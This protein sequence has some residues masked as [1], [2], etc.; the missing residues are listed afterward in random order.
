MNIR[1]HCENGRTPNVLQLA[2]SGPNLSPPVGVAEMSAKF[3][4]MDGE[5]YVEEE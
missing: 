2:R 3:R 5:V 1:L 4:E